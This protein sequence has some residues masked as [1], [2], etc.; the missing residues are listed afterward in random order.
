MS[1]HVS[2][3]AKIPVQEGLNYGASQ[4]MTQRFTSA[5]GFLETITLIPTCDFSRLD[6]LVI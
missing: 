6:V 3:A 2:V 1:C 5:V 4:L